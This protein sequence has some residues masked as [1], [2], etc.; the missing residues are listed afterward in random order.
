[1]E[2]TQKTG[3][4]PGSV[5]IAWKNDQ[6]RSMKKQWK[7]ANNTITGILPNRVSIENITN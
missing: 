6:T 3:T 1:M 4:W 7:K 2:F 5:V